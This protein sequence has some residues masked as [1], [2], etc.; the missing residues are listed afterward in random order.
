MQTVLMQRPI[1]VRCFMP[2]IQALG[3]LRWEDCR[4][5]EASLGFIASSTSADNSVETLSQKRERK[6][7]RGS[8]THRKWEPGSNT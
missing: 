6:K 1:S 5:L 3:R 2:G 7:R 8:S 4:E